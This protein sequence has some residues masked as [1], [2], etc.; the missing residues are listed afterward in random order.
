MYLLLG[1]FELLRWTDFEVGC[2]QPQ[3]HPGLVELALAKYIRTHV[4]RFM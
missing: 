2:H 3:V 4:V 1:S